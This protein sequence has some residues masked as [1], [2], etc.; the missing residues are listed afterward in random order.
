[1]HPMA[2]SSVL[3]SING[4]DMPHSW[5]NPHTGSLTCGVKATM[6]GMAKWKS[7][8]MFLLRKTISAI[9]NSWRDCRNQCAIKDL[10]DA[11]LV[12][13][14]T[15]P[16]NWPIWPVQKTDESWRMKVYYHKLTQVLT[17]TAVAV[18]DAVSLLEQINTSL[19]TWCTAIDLV[20][21]FS[22]LLSIRSHRSSLLSAA[23]TSNT[24]P[25]LTYLMGVSVLQPY[26]IIQFT[27]ILTAIPFHKLSH[28]PLH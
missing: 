19:G 22:P 12:I 13:S 5:Q 20:S 6:V 23:K 25:S 15:S 28:G 4:I 10:K 8:E 11:E 16:F 9:L 7:L 18:L 17:P 26:V 2:I 3:E 27:G 14:T 24:P 21:A 1:M